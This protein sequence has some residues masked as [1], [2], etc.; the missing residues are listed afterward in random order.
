VQPGKS[1]PDDDDISHAQPSVP[2]LTP[3]RLRL[4]AL[5]RERHDVPELPEAEKAR[6]RLE[7]L[8]VGLRIAEVEDSDTWVCRPHAPGELDAALRGS[9]VT[10]ARR[11][12]KFLWLETD[13][14]HELGL[15]LGMGGSIQ[16]NQ[17]PSPRNWDRVAIVFE[18]ESRMALRDKRRLSRARLG[19]GIEKLGPDAATITPA[20]FRK[21]VG[22]GRG[23]I[24][25]RLLDQSVLAGV[26]NL[27]ADEALWLAEIDPRIAANALADEHLNALHKGLR[28]ALRDALQP[29]GGSG[30][31][32]FAK[33]RRRGSCPRCGSGLDRDTVGGRTTYWCIDEQSFN[34]PT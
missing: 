15:H 5:A 18:D 16:S 33:S 7:K 1:S 9:I 13:N 11:H 8:C 17:T 12:G 29:K 23:P 34:P 28:R 31:G 21:R 25:A 6:L 19:A 2:C 22:G 20:V 3:S 32:V 4:R 10:A 30:R 27:L 24:K 26:G 14:G